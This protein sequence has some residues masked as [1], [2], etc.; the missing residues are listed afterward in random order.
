[1]LIFNRKLG[2]QPKAEENVSTLKPTVKENAN[3]VQTIMTNMKNKQKYSGQKRIG[4]HY[5]G[6]EFKEYCQY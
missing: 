1:M 4:R 3:S 6:I 2:R 5:V